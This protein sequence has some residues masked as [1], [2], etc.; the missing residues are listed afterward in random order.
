MPDP[1]GVVRRGKTPAGGH[2]VAGL[3]AEVASVDQDRSALHGDQLRDTGKARIGRQNDLRVHA[4][5]AKELQVLPQNGLRQHDPEHGGFLLFLGPRFGPVQHE[6][7]QF[8]VLKGKGNAVFQLK[9]QGL[10]HALAVIEGERYDSL[11]ELV[12][13]DGRDDARAC[14]VPRFFA[15]EVRKLNVRG[16]RNAV[17]VLELRLAQA[18]VHDRHGKLPFLDFQ[19]DDFHNALQ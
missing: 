18:L 7:V 2:V 12:A 14:P 15:Q 16:K 17:G 6:V 1:A 8:N 9:G 10:F 13:G 11:A 19:S 3:E 5:S 4:G